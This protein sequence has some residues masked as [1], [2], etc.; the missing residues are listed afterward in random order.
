MADGECEKVHIVMFPWLAFGH[1]IPY[2]ELAKL[3]SQKG[4]RVS[5]LSTPRNIDRLPKLPPELENLIDYV[6]FPL[7]ATNDLPED[8]EAT[9][10][11]PYDEVQYLK[12]AYDRLCDPVARFLESSC[13]DWILY[14]FAPFWVGRI[15]REQGIKTASFS[16][17][18]AAFL[19]FVGPTWAIMGGDYRKT[20]EDFTVAPSWVPFR[21][22]VAFRYFE[23]KRIFDVLEA[24]ASGVSDFYRFGTGL[25]S[26]DILAVRSSCEVEPEWLKLLEEIHQKPVFPV[27]QLPP[28]DYLGEEET[29]TWQ[30]IKD[31]LDLQKRG[32]VVY[33]AF[34]SEA[35]PSQLELTEIALGLEQSGMPFFWVLK[36][37]RG[38]SDKDK[39][40]L[41]DGFEESVKGRGVVCTS[42]VP[43]LRILAHNSVGGFLTHSGW[44]SVVEALSLERALILLTFLADQGVNA[45]LLEE[46]KSV[47]RSRG[48]TGTDR[49]RGSRWPS[50]SGW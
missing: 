41:P 6:K 20:P 44:T 23:I 13:P 43:Q 37:R 26:A 31:W 48:A 42:W 22:N 40:E 34:G 30:W 32:S 10:D 7:P 46:K 27:G 29:G 3:I 39:I 4:H 18:I 19:G 38:S 35:K 28:M 50:R 15:A 49:S 11:L 16:I 1:M 17:F 14:D 5:F 24:N 2:M 25:E 36:T 33:V 45:R 9:S 8:A 21:T 47:T 12:K